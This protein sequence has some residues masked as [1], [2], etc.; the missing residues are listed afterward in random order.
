MTNYERHTAV[1]DEERREFLKVIGVAGAV[2]ASGVTL[3]ELNSTVEPSNVEALSAVG[4]AVSEEMAGGVNPDLLATQQ[5]ELA[6]ALSA[7]PAAVESGAAFRE[8]GSAF[9]DIAEAGWLTHDHLAETGF[10]ETLSEEMP[11]FNPERLTTSTQ[12]FLGSSAATAPLTDLDLGGT[13]GVDLVAPIINQAEKLSHFHWI[14]SGDIPAEHQLADVLPPISQR[15]AGGVL[16][17]L[18]NLDDHLYQDQVLLNEQILADG[19]WEVRG[20]TAGFYLMAEGAK[21]VSA[22]SD[23]F[24]DAELGALFA[25]SIALQEVAQ[26][27]LPVHM[28]WLD[29]AA[30]DPGNVKIDSISI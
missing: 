7:A 6:T 4:A 13:E 30:R 1:T 22:D 20:M 29:E 27:M 2:G 15:A 18:Q 23:R 12:A 10:F 16:L 25:T 19:I 21:A 3:G 14:A 8:P 11:A 9:D 17:W 26:R 24:T 5:A 28:H